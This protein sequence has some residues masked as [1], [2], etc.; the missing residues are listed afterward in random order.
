MCVS[1]VHDFP[2]EDPTGAYCPEHG[3]TILF[4]NARNPRNARNTP[5]PPEDPPPHD[6]HPDRPAR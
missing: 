5:T 3:A 2:F 4:H 6:H 1:G